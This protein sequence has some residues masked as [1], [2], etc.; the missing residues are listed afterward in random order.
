MGWEEQNR[1]RE[2]VERM[3]ERDGNVLLLHLP[4]L[5]DSFHP[6]SSPQRLFI[7]GDNCVLTFTLLFVAIKN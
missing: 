5:V 2:K 6:H 4:F 1:L 3:K 7:G